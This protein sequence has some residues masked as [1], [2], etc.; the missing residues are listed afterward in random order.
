MQQVAARQN[1][2]TPTGKPFPIPSIYTFNQSSFWLD[3]TL[4]QLD[5]FRFHLI[6][7]KEACVLIKKK[8]K[9]IS[10]PNEQS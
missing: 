3:M 8:H 10:T 5:K 6:A 4:N 1:G 7:L 2:L 9:A